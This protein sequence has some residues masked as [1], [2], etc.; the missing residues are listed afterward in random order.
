M[1]ENFISNNFEND[2]LD[3][4][5]EESDYANLITRL[6]EIKKTIAILEKRYLIKI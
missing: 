6:K 2:D 4:N 3:P 5:S 1:N